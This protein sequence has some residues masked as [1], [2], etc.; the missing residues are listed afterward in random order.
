MYH[1]SQAAGPP[2]LKGYSMKYVSA[3]LMAAMVT[4]F[5]GCDNA[6]QDKPKDILDEF[7]EEPVTITWEGEGEG[8]TEGEGEPE[9]TNTVQ[10]YQANV[11]VYRMNSR[12]DTAATLSQTYRMAV[13]NINEKI[14]TRIDFDFDAIMPFR[15]IISN[16]EELIMVNP[17]LNLVVS[18][19]PVAEKDTPLY[20]LLANETGLSRINIPL[21]REKA[22]SLSID[23]QEDASAKTL[24]LDL[25]A[26]LIPQNGADKIIRS[27]ALFDTANNI[28]LNTEVVMVREDKTTVTTT[29]SPVY[30]MQ[31]G[32]PVKVGA[33]TVIQSKAA[34]LIDG[35]AP[36]L[37]VYNSPD[38]IPELSETEFARLQESGSIHE[39]SGMTFGSLADLSY[40][41]TIYEVYQDIE[42]N[43][44]PDQL[45]RLMQ[46]GGK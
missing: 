4:L 39:I 26:S 2:F 1:F 27:S 38:D 12:K 36:D 41:E 35:I 21:I 32:V 30:N 17:T 14:F 31:A 10:S 40:T 46:E 37:P 13:K 42:I 23:L 20:R 16:G 3:L 24:L 18:R 9:K 22:K 44:V 45:C 8:A 5:L 19:V 15:T 33:V 25:S 11:Q 6:A 28:L 7:R 34:E 29:V 43:N